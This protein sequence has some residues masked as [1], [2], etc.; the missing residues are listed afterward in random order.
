M[1]LFSLFVVVVVVVLLFVLSNFAMPEY[2]CVCSL[3]NTY[4]CCGMLRRVLL[5]VCYLDLVEFTYL[6]L[7]ACW[8]RVTVG[9]SDLFVLCSCY[10]IRAVLTPFIDST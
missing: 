3:V 7:L 1:I 9:V 6:D 8:A 5:N 4:H 2:L 10:V